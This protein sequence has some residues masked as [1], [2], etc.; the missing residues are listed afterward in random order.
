M[1]NLT[2]QRQD[3]VQTKQHNNKLYYQIKELNFNLQH[4]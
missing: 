2:R 3:G 1:E 4:N